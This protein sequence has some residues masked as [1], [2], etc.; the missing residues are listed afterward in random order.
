M[1]RPH[2]GHEDMPTVSFRMGRE[3]SLANRPGITNIEARYAEMV[4][5]IN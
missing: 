4:S 1:N 2:C 5:E 3:D